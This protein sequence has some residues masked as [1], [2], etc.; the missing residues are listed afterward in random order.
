MEIENLK[1]ISECVHCFEET[2]SYISYLPLINI[3]KNFLWLAGSRFTFYTEDDHDKIKIKYA[4][5]NFDEILKFSS[6][7]NCIL[8][9]IDTERKRKFYFKNE[10]DLFYYKLLGD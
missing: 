7:I 5:T 8:Q 10:L 2:F 1:K 6:E 3:T 9:I 4:K